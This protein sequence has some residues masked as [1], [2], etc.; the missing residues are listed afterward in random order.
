M[1][2]MRE[3]CLF[4][5]M[6]TRGEEEKSTQINFQFGCSLLSDYHLPLQADIRK[7]PQS[8]KSLKSKCT[9]GRVWPEQVSGI[10]FR[11][12]IFK[13][14]RPWQRST[15]GAI[16]DFFRTVIDHT[17]KNLR[18]ISLAGTWRRR[19]YFTFLLRGEHSFEAIKKMTAKW[20]SKTRLI[21]ISLN[22]RALIEYI[23]NFVGDS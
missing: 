23:W 10:C 21:W 14:E 22:F 4:R 1:K 15:L 16:S 6:I 17:D 13:R 3:K 12:A 20:T 19:I 11:L 9:T 8:V 2:V 5:S 7:Y 18:T